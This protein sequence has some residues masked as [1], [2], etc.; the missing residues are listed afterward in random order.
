MVEIKITIPNSKVDEF[1]AGFLRAYPNETGIT[2]LAHIKKFIREQCVN[3][4]TTG[5]ILIAQE[6]TEPEIDTE[7]VEE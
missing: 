4:Y 3:Y 5:K 6:T 2:D 1:K 7:I